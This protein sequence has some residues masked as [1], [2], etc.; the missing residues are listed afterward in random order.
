MKRGRLIAASA[1]FVGLALT[2]MLFP[3]V[4]DGM[5]TKLQSA[6]EREAASVPAFRSLERRLSPQRTED[7]VSPEASAPPTRRTQFVSYYVED[8]RPSGETETPSEPEIVAAFLARQA[9]FSG[10]ALPENVDYGYIALP[11]AFTLPLSGRQSSGFGYRLH[12]ILET[13]KFH[14]GTD[15]AA[16]WGETVAAFA[17]G[18]VIE[19]GYDES[20]GWH[21][22]LDHGGGWV[23]HY[24]HCSKLL[25]REGQTV[26]MGEVIALV[27]ATGLA[28]GPHLHFELTHDGVFVNPEYYLDA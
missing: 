11:F 28:T 13:V 23:S 1:A 3:D 5:R 21:L 10:Y 12:P 18:T 19:S 9:E 26:A 14:Y 22:K 27:G 6:L 15:V 8:A 4:G 20:Y 2:K 7:P 25:A 17:D 24:C 16:Q